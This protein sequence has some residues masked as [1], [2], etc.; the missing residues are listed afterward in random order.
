MVVA[1]AQRP[2]AVVLNR[3]S[4]DI[5]EETIEA[6]ALDVVS[7]NLPA[8]GIADQ[9][10]VAEEAEIC[11]R[12]CHTPGRIQPRPFSSRCNSL[13]LGE[14]LSTNPKPGKSKSSCFVAFCLA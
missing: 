8:P 9:Q 6:P 1:E 13:P 5:A 12:Q 3:M 4:V 14:N 2:Q 7:S 10:V 11:R